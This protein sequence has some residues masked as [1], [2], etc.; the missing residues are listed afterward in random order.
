[1]KDRL[2]QFVPDPDAEEGEPETQEARLAALAE[3]QTQCVLHATQFPA[4]HTISYSTCSIHEV[5]KQKHEE[6][7][8]MKKDE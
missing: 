6:E 8:R 7:R 3:F 4:V 5:A 2:E 1:M